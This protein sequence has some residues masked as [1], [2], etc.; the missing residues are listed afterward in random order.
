M[1]LHIGCGTVY[2]RDW[3]NVDLPLKNVFLHYER[4]D[5]MAK[6]ITDE[7]D[8]Y[9]RHEGK[10]Q[11][12]VKEPLL[13][14]SVCDVYG[15]F[16]FIP[17]RRESVDEILARQVFE[18]LSRHEAEQGLDEAYNVL[19]TDG[20][21]RIDIPDPDETLRKYRETGDE[22]Y[23]RHLFGP[24]RDQYGFH[25]HYTRGML[26]EMANERGFSFVEEEP[27]IHFYPSFC[28][29]FTKC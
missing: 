4:P 16:G 15:R 28:L 13:Q 27:N 1:K 8:Y 26:I 24:R 23:I 11:E 5:L 17:A 22:F 3:I 14:E 12:T 18:H 7:D 9:G 20:I 10:K 2:L 6:W 25:V 19:V 29:R 21:L